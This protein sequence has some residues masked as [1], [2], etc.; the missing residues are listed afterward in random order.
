MG[1]HIRTCEDP[2]P[3][4]R[5]AYCGIIM[6][7]SCVR[8]AAIAIMRTSRTEHK[9]AAVAALSFGAPGDR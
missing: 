4:L 1:T 6:V 8:R 2:S 9:G 5:T 7:I 3:V